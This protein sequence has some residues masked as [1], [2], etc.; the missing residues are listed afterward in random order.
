MT[1]PTSPTSEDHQMN[2]S[3]TKIHN[4]DLNPS[5]DFPV[6][7]AQT[8]PLGTRI[9]NTE[10]DTDSDDFHVT[11]PVVKQPIQNKPGTSTAKE[12]VSIE[13][14]EATGSSEDLDHL[15]SDEFIFTFTDDED[16][17]KTFKVIR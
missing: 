17:D 2:Q 10:S 13:I 1:T 3:G 14:D 6:T 5:G 12:K 16:A 4:E 9:L 8:I 15:E 7:Q 11:Q